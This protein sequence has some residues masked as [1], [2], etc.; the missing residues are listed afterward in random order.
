M[1]HGELVGARSGGAAAARR[2][3]FSRRKQLTCNLYE[4]SKHPVIL[5]NL[6]GVYHTKQEL[7]LVVLLG[8]SWC[9][10]VLFCAFLCFLGFL[11][12]SENTHLG[13]FQY[14]YTCIKPGKVNIVPII[15]TYIEEGILYIPL[16]EG[17]TYLYI[18]T[19]FIIL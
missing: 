10:F 6:H 4:E 17:K 5:S 1:P 18:Y 16:F 13:T 2:R 8:A 12:R 15:G 19:P 3:G 7:L 9:F 14:I 11:K